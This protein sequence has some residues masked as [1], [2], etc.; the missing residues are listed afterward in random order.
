MF[1]GWELTERDDSESYY[2]LTNDEWWVLFYSDRIEVHWGD[3]E[4]IQDPT[5]YQ[6]TNDPDFPAQFTQSVKEN[7]NL[8]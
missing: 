2:A 3:Y 5:V 4:I 1:E 8:K 6:A 7:L